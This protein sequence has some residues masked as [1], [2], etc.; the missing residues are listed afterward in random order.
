MSC[1]Q[2]RLQLWP[3]SRLRALVAALLGMIAT[4]AS[5]TTVVVVWTPTTTVIGTDSLTH[6]LDDEEHS[7]K[8][9]IRRA[10]SV[11]WA[12]TGI[13]GNPDLNFSL[14][15]V[16]AEAMSRPGGFDARIRTFE[17]AL[18]APLSEVVANIR[19]ENPSWYGR[20]AKGLAVTRVIFS[21]SEDGVTRFWLREFVAESAWM[22][23]GVT[24]SVKRTDCPGPACQD[25]RVFLLGQ[26][27]SARKIADDAV[28]WERSGTAEGVRRSIEAEIAGN[29]GHVGPPIAIAEVM[30]NGVSWIEKGLCGEK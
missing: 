24:I 16:I 29:P 21:T 28:T 19:S 23:R 9:K 26:Y 1:L 27:D 5:A 22:G 4:Q 30:N 2:S 18:Q 7:S 3:A 15:R 17:A 25:R 12:A 13:T 11:V 14:D 6:T 8:C 20:R 10:G